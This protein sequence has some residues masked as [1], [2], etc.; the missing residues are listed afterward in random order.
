MTKEN[1]N[2]ATNLLLHI[3]GG[4]GKC[5]M[6]TAVISSYKRTYPDSKVVVVSG[7]PLSL[8]RLLR[9]PRLESFCA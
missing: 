5:I 2:I 1:K 9:K 3:N 4:L 6:A 8:A 7:Y